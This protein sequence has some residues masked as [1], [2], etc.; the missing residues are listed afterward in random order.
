[1][2]TEHQTERPPLT[3]GA[4]QALQK[5]GDSGRHLPPTPITCEDT[6]LARLSSCRVP[7]SVSI[8]RYPVLSKIQFRQNIAAILKE[9]A[10]SS[11][12]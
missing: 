7:F 5:H 6:P 8:I 10:K 9:V 12:I 4:K 2:P 1:M 11:P 3:S